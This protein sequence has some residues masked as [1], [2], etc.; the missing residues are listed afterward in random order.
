M[1]DQLAALESSR[2][3]LLRQI[4]HIQDMRPGSIN[5][6]FRRCGKSSCHCAHPSDPGHGPHFQLTPK[7]D[8]KTLTQTLSSRAAL[9]KAEQEVAEFRNFEKLSQSLVEVNQKIC[10]LRPVEGKATPWTS[11]EKKRLTQSTRKW[12]A[13]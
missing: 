3:S 5:V 7:K 4:A 2:T 13:K 6:V 11:E 1:P 9:D 12:R 8:G 10:Q